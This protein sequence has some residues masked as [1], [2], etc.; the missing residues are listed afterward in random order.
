M[1]YPTSSRPTTVCFLC[2]NIINSWNG[3]S[4]FDVSSL[5]DKD[6]RNAHFFVF[7]FRFSFGA[8]KRICSFLENVQFINLHKGYITFGVV[9]LHNFIL[10]LHV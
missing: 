5:L 2:K 8:L 9:F 1:C 6:L 7:S 10:F 3:F 4:F